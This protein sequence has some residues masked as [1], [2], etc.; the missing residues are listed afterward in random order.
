MWD[1]HR[2]CLTMVDKAAVAAIQDG[3][4]RKNCDRNVPASAVF[5]RCLYE[6]FNKRLHF[7]L[8]CGEDRNGTVFSVALTLCF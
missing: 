1:S 6:T 8:N 3:F 4:Q 7:S 2:C 5:N